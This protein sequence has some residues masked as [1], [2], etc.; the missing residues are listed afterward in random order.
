MEYFKGANVSSSLVD[1]LKSGFTESKISSLTGLEY[2]L[3]KQTYKDS[4]C[5][6]EAI[7]PARRSISA[8]INI[9]QTYFPSCTDEEVIIAIESLPGKCIITCPK[10]RKVT[11][12]ITKYNGNYY[13]LYNGNY[14]TLTQDYESTEILDK[15]TIEYY[16]KII[17]EWNTLKTQTQ[18][19]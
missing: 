7:P 9:C 10:I 6:I 16:K 11:V 4:D 1:L 3:F 14:Y 19:P 12:C 13:T 15:F 5:T 18:N 17:K 8:L 2:L